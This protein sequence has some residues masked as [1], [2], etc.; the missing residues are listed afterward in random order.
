MN[1]DILL[2]YI[3]LLILSQISISEYADVICANV[4][5]AIVVWVEKNFLEQ[6]EEYLDKH[7]HMISSACHPTRLVL[8]ALSY[9]HLIHNFKCF[10][11][12]E[13]HVSHI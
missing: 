4:S 8:L 2:F 11:C 13:I 1:S 7:L 3:K 5:N 10:L 12:I 9:F 6:T